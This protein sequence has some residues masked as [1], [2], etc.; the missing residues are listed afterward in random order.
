MRTLLTFLILVVSVVRPVPIAA[1]PPGQTLCI[2]DFNRLGDEDSMD[3]LRRGLADMMI[4]TMNRVSLFQIVDRTRLMEIL[5]THGAG[6]SGPVDV[7]TEFRQARLVKAQFLLVGNY[8][9]RSGVI[10][11]QTRL[12]RVADQEIIAAASWEG[13]RYQ[14]P[15]APR[16]LSIQLV[17][18]INRPLDLTRFTGI[19]HELAATV[20][21]AE[22]FYQGQTA[23]DN[24][25]YPD[26]LAYYADA[27][28]NAGDFYRIHHALIEMYYLLEQPVHAVIYARNIGRMLE[29]R[30]PARALQFYFIAAKHSLKA[31]N[32]RPMAIDLL[33]SIDHLAVQYEDRTHEAEGVRRYVTQKVTELSGTGTYETVASVLLTPDIRFNLWTT[34]I[35]DQLDAAQRQGGYRWMKQNGTWEKAPIPQP[36]VFMWR[37]RALLELARAYVKAGEV[38]RA[39]ARY[40]QI[41]SA[42][43]FLQDLPGYTQQERVYWLQGIRLEAHFMTMYHYEHTGYLARDPVL[44][45]TVNEVGHRQVFMR[46]FVDSSPDPR[47]RVWS[48]REDGGHEFFDFAAPEG[49]QI[50]AVILGVHVDGFAQCSVALPNARG[51]PPQFD[52]SRRIDRK[53][54]YSGVYNERIDLP[55]GTEFMS[56]SVLWG[57]RWIENP[58]QFV[59]R[60]IA[61]LFGDVPEISWWEATF[62]ISPKHDEVIAR[63]TVDFEAADRILL[64]EYVK[65]FGW[66]DGQV[67]RK[68]T[69]GD[70][71]LPRNTSKTDWT[72]CAVDGDIRVMS[73]DEPA[74]YIPLPVTINTNDTEWDPAPVQTRQ[75]AYALV[76]GRG[77]RKNPTGYFFSITA[78][79]IQWATPRRMMFEDANNP[80][81]SHVE[82]QSTRIVSITDRYMMLLDGGYVRY[83]D[84]M[85][86]WGPPEKQF[87]YDGENALLKSRDGRIWTVGTQHINEQILPEAEIDPSFG[88][89][90]T[91]NGTRYRKADAITVTSSID[92]VRWEPERVV[93]IG[94]ETSGLWAFPLGDDDIGIA[95]SYQNYHLVWLASTRTGTFTV[96]ESPVRLLLSGRDIR[97][98][99]HN[100]AVVCVRTVHD[101]VEEQWV[102]M[103]QR[104]R[105]IYKR[106]NLLN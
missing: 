58:W 89:Y 60:F 57:A 16:S 9:L 33:E 27:A 36:T 96:I 45:P 105:A 43:E 64:R 21:V 1:Q 13:L 11:I 103:V 54:W 32:N 53:T 47:A 73:Q 66:D 34:D 74:L 55:K 88:Y 7:D 106:I 78:D 85:Q 31:L 8:A 75:G 97:F 44:L 87:G 30:D 69:T 90:T 61:R 95:V 37:I 20:S 51:W 79:F 6:T 25:Q 81:P 41:L 52:L 3:W 14:I 82:K 4:T 83:S 49:Y 91:A 22:A 17:R 5:Q 12:I 38:D 92:G 56:C 62:L 94:K 104:S 2:L 40:K 59:R 76:W 72:A 93:Y 46:D 100:D 28:P 71:I 29:T 68:E 67:L 10:A 86:H 42:Y 65:R 48:Q 24:G 102:V 35:D 26:A 77:Y 50:D 80:L 23:F 99:T 84:D 19:E 63:N 70:P 39:L 98:F 101:F 18:G 15:Q